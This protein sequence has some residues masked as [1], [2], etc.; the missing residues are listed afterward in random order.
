MAKKR[1]D[2]KRDEMREVSG[3]KNRLKHDVEFCLG[4]SMSIL[5][6]GKYARLGSLINKVM[7]ENTPEAIRLKVAA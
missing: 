3:E 2:W 7:I 6:P 1:K 4:Q 5:S